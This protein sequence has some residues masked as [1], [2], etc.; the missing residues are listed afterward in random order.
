MIIRIEQEN[1]CGGEDGSAGGGLKELDP[2]QERRRCTRVRFM[3]QVFL[4]SCFPALCCF[5][6]I[7]VLKELGNLASWFIGY[8]DVHQFLLVSPLSWFSSL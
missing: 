4:F 2:S 1:V 7:L 5:L 6:S 8:P 3:K